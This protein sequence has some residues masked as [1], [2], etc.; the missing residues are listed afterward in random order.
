MSA[1]PAS[2]EPVGP[3][4]LADR[5]APLHAE[6]IGL[7]E[8]LAPEN[9]QR[10]TA[11]ALWSVQDIVAHLLDSALRRLS[12]QRDGVLP[13][14]GPPLQSHRD[15]VAYLDR[16]NAEWVA[17][18]RRLSPEVLIDLHRFTGPRVAELFRSLDPH[19]PAPFAVA[20][21]GES[22]SENWFDI[23]REYTEQWLHQ[24]Q[25]RDAVAAPGLTEREWMHPVLELFV[26]A[27]PFSYRRVPAQ[28]GAA[29]RFQITG[30]AGGEWT[31]LRFEGEWRLY[32]GGTAAA[33][34]SVRLSQDTA[35][36]LFS[37]GLPAGVAR[38]RISITGDQVLGAAVLGALA[39]MA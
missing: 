3:V 28:A 33:A 24:Q 39:V 21:A 12:F 27:L 15:L 30:E 17:A 16:L 6:L 13:P 1:L 19:G 36:R 18:A 26:R 4:Y 10:P 34:A 31:L 37:K 8:R 35:W 2:L 11:C 29:V 23:G 7:L 5:F 38:Q 22:S 14:P 20:W 32:S 25:I 9:W